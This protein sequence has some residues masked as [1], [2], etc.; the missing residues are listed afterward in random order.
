VV[1]QL[2][3][4]LR[5]VQVDVRVGRERRTDAGGG[6]RRDRLAGTGIPGPG[7]TLRRRVFVHR[8]AV[9]V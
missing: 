5:Y 4:L 9:A 8:G 1:A 7:R 6:G 3:A 2:L